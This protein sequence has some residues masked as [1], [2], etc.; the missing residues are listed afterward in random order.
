MKKLFTVF[1]LLFIIVF[2]G[3]SQGQNLP[4][5]L[6]G[7][8]EGKATFYNGTQKE[9]GLHSL[10]GVDI[11]ELGCQNCHPGSMTYQN[12]E[13]FTDSTYDPLSCYNCHDA[14]FQVAQ[15][16]ACKS[17]HGRIGKQE[18]MGITDIHQT[19]YNLK[20][21][22]CH[23][24]DDIHGD[25]NSYV[26]MFDEHDNGD[27]TYN[28]A[29][30]ADCEDCHTNLPSNPEHAQHMSDIHCSTCHTAQ[31]VSCYNCH[32]N[33]MIDSHQKVAAGFLRGF[34]LI[35]HRTGNKYN[36]KIW[37]ATFQSVYYR[38]PDGK[39]STFFT[40]VPYY[41][42]NVVPKSEAK[43]CSDCHNNPNVQAYKTTGELYIA[44]WN[45]D[46]AK[47]FGISGVVPI[48]PDF[49]TA[50]KMDFLEQDTSNGT[51]HTVGENQADLVQ[52]M[53]YI[54]PLTS[55]EM[56]LLETPQAIND[57]EAIAKG[58]ELKQNYPNPFN[59]STTIEFV[60]PEAKRISLK[61]YNVLGEEVAT[62]YNNALLSAGTHTV[63][64]NASNL[65]SGVYFYKLISDNVTITR[66][67]VLMK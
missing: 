39:D 46:S 31:V 3:Y 6:H 25:G 13:T 15:P 27:G 21:S 32:F 20:C 52:N 43:T 2:L 37:P 47:V 8:R 33:Q 16:E 11:A 56:Q 63:Q 61:V 53:G 65:T 1:A 57:D 54:V 34:M 67:M 22:D 28:Y 19:Q 12:G 41:S 26:S 35:G 58:Y 36:G 55:E 23:S 14:S 64:F 29:I 38:T 17:C 7:T 9:P 45:A 62:I 59:P 4:T 49:A 48:P 50:F 51:W 40:L 30:D 66:K 44:K 24:A 10:T 5:S 42:H 18:M 60:L